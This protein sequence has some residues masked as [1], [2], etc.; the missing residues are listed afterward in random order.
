M[1]VEPIGLIALLV[2]MIGLFVEQSFIVYAFFASTLLGAAAALILN[3]LGGATIQP[4]HLLLGFL[5]VKLLASRNVRAGALR[6]V[7]VGSPGF[8]LLVTVGYATMTAYLLPRFFHGQTFAFSTRAQGE[9]YAAPLAPTT[10]NLTQS[11]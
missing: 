5:T 1:T 3:S 8:W 7:A 4:A 6:A 11:V 10:A 9:N 2:G